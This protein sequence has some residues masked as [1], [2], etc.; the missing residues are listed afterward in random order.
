MTEY[1]PIRAT[2]RVVIGAAALVLSMSAADAQTGSTRQPLVTAN[3]PLDAATQER[4]G[5]VAL[6]RTGSNPHCSGVMLTNTWIATAAHCLTQ[7]RDRAEPGRLRVVAN[8]RAPAGTPRDG[9]QEAA[10]AAVHTFWSHRTE[11]DSP[12]TTFDIA[13]VRLAAPI[14]VNG[15]LTGYAAVLDD[16]TI[17]GLNGT[18][19]DIFGRGINQWASGP[20][21]APVASMGDNRYR[22][23]QVTVSGLRLNTQTAPAGGFANIVQYTMTGTEGVAGGD[24]GG[25]S[26]RTGP[27]GVP[28]LVGVHSL[29][30]TSCLL[31]GRCPDSDGSVWRRVSGVEWCGDAPIAP[32]RSAI[33]DLMAQTWDP[34]RPLQVVNIRHSERPIEPHL[35]LGDLDS[36]HWAE[37]NRAVQTMCVNRGFLAGIATGHHVIGER[38]R[39]VCFA[40]G[41]ARR[42]DTAAALAGVWAVHDRDQADWARAGRSAA[43]ICHQTTPG[44]AGGF[45][46]GY[47]VAAS[48]IIG[49]EIGT[50]CL[51]DSAGRWVD[52]PASELGAVA[53]LGAVTWAAAFRLASRSCEARGHGLGGFL[54]GHEG[55]GVRGAV[56][57]GRSGVIDRAAEQTRPTD[58]Y[59]RPSTPLQDM[60]RRTSPQ[61]GMRR[62]P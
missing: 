38:Y 10:G 35:A 9:I 5:L 16:M 33:L 12:A 26:F 6:R 22:R 20:A 25:P 11:D 49:L 8:W 53:N 34:T 21:D 54:N 45:H 24:S 52:L 19:L 43:D 1:D 62:A 28:R 61:D 29:C 60:I 37:V 40:A 31:Q 48:G 23:A 50:V 32:V 13:L 27:D 39:V 44:S 15:N 4:L 18:V 56:C 42:F 7:F 17:T 41:A 51:D 46:T 36:M 57:L 30:V 47:G 3:E 59:T 58:T 14:A 2:A 55:P